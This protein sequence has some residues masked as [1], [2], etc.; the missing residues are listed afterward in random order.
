LAM[1]SRNHHRRWMATEHHDG[2]SPFLT[3]KGAPDELLAMASQELANGTSAPL[4]EARRREILSANDRFAARGLR[5]LGVARS[6]EKLA[7]GDPAGLTWL[8]LVALAD[9]IR[10]EAREAIAT[11]HRAGIR[12]IM[13][14]GDQSATALAVAEE[15]TLSRTGII[16]V[17]ET[18]RL[19]G[20][21][22]RQ[23]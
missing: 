21:D 8:G 12:T 15:L 4:D 18:S 16:P 1:R 11:F 17:L 7:S 22:D 10:A 3:L 5:V 6:Q 14:T 19:T 9:P 2:D 13:L 23:V 20:L